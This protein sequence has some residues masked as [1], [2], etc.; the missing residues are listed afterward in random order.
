MVGV[1]RRLVAEDTL[2]ADLEARGG[3]GEVDCAG[4]CLAR[5]RK[6]GRM[7]RM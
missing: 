1:R 3:S 6:G 5:R 2:D 4:T 7:C